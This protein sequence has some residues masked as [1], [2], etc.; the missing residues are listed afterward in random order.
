MTGGTLLAI[1][2]LPKNRTILTWNF[3]IMA[4][5]VGLRRFL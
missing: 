3:P 2:L 5:Y 1:D 4:R